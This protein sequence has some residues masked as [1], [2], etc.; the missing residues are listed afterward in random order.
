MAGKGAWD[1]TQY[2]FLDVDEKRKFCALCVKRRKEG[3]PSGFGPVRMCPKDSINYEEMLPWLSLGQ[4]N[5][6]LVTGY[7]CEEVPSMDGKE[8]RHWARMDDD[9]LERAKAEF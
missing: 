4:R 7:K 8:E 1:H 2:D 9:E 5:F 3:G 6:L